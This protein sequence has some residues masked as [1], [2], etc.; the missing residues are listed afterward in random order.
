MSTEE[1]LKLNYFPYY[2]KEEILE[3]VKTWIDPQLAADYTN[4]YY[5]R[6]NNMRKRLEEL[7]KSGKSYIEIWKILDDEFSTNSEV[8]CDSIPL[9]LNKD[10]KPKQQK[11]KPAILKRLS[12]PKFTPP[13]KKRK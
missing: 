3:K 7:S 2:T 9:T 4:A 11:A 5:D 8:T 13:K 6:F 1:L 12:G 10:D